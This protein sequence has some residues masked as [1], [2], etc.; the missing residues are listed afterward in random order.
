MMLRKSD[1]LRPPSMELTQIRQL[2]GLLTQSIQSLH[3]TGSAITPNSQARSW[4]HTIRDHNVDQ[5][6][7]GVLLEL[8]GLFYGQEEH[9]EVEHWL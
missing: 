1:P 8:G 5:N 6:R 4:V 7:S 9:D 2:H 3:T